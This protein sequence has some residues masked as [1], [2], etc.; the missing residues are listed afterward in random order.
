MKRVLALAAV[1]VIPATFLVGCGGDDD[2]S[3]T[4]TTASSSR[5]D[6]GSSDSGSSD[7]G[8]SDSGSSDTG[9]EK[10][11]KFCDDAK[12]LAEKSKKAID[13]KDSDL[14]KEAADDAKALTD[15]AKD[16]TSEVLSDP[17]LARALADCTGE[18]ANVGG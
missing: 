17:S 18:L 13:H 7:S 11:D 10:V 3:A 4:S 6:S 2:S 5:E 1:L 14:A 16:L 8:S 9:N 15:Q 12:A